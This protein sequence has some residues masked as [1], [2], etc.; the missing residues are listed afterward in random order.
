[1][2]DQPIVS[3]ARNRRAH[4]RF[5]DTRLK[6]PWTIPPMAWL[7]AILLWGILLFVLHFG[8]DLHVSDLTPGQRAPFTVTALVDFESVNLAETEIQ[9]S[10]AFNEATPVFE[11]SEAG[12]KESLR[13]LAKLL[14]RAALA[15]QQETALAPL[16]VDLA[17]AIDLMNLPRDL[18]QLPAFFSSNQLHSLR[19]EGSRVLESLSRAGLVA[20]DARDSGFQGAAPQG[21][22]RLGAEGRIVP[23]ANLALPSEA[24]QRASAL[25]RD[26]QGYS[27]EQE[28]LVGLL[29]DALFKANLRLEPEATRL[30]REN[31]RKAVEPVKDTKR[32]GTTLM[33]ARTRIGAQ[34]LED[35]KAHS[36]KLRKVEDGNP[37]WG[38][39][40]GHG[41]FLAVTLVCSLLLLALLHAK[42]LAKPGKIILW[43]LLSA[44]PLLMSKG[45]AYLSVDMHLFPG[46]ML[47]PLLP[48]AL[49][50][51]LATILHGPRFALAVGLS[52]SAGLALQ[53]DGDLGVFLTSLAITLVAASAARAIH[54]RSNLFRAGIW[55]GG[56]KSLMVIGMGLTVQVTPAILAQQA[57]GAFCAGLASS[58]LVLLL[59]PPFELIF[60]VTTDIRLLELSDM[61]N[62][63]LSR[64]AMEAPATYHHSLMVAHLAQTA[65]REVGANDLLVRVCAYYHDIGKM[66]K[67][68]F[69]IENIQGRHNPHDDL[70]PSMSRLVVISHV[71]E[72]V[73]LAHRYKLPR[74]ILDGIEQHH[75][76]S[77]IQY[78]YH[79]ARMQEEGKDVDKVKVRQEDYRYPGPK[80]KTLE[81]G[82]LMM[83]DSIEAASRTID[84]SK[85][86]QVEGLVNEIVREKIIDGQFDECAITLTQIAAIRR[87]FVFSLNNMLHGRIAYPKDEDRDHQPAGSLPAERTGTGTLRPLDHGTG[88]SPGA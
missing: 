63:L 13:D 21:K 7:M 70:S 4:Q 45:L 48:Y 25:L 83:A 11:V 69:F 49:A 79:R 82:I 51:L 24:A 19:L 29:M 57:V 46:F 78:F 42:L 67:P 59:I 35:L 39:I 18:L 12:L 47:R 16:A 31:A 33:E 20:A 40:A 41:I 85:P 28:R 68:E 30:A 2:T 14:D 74:V 8:R 38:R 88:T 9:R 64:L 37:R 65:A 62:P 15:K 71:K 56:V 80:P 58:I 32:Q 81:M 22:I 44:A 53:H 87:S 76:T 60:K 26:S 5:R 10:R 86:G 36:E 66:T 6:N 54:K 1:M 55:I 27:A 72:G 77:V 34:T 50:P 73:S 52:S 17:D 75:G 3:K 61:S 43:M 23:I 84:K